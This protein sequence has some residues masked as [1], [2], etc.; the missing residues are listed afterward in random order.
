VAALSDTTTDQSWTYRRTPGGAASSAVPGLLVL[1]SGSEARL[2]PIPLGPGVNVIGRDG[3][4]GPFVQDGRVSRRHAEVSFDGAGWH[5]HDLGSR[6][7]TFLDGEPLKK[8]IVTDSSRVLRV[9][10]TLFGLMSDLRAF[11]ATS[12][13]RCDNVVLGPTLRSVWRE[14]EQAAGF[15]GVLH[16]TGES[17]SGKEL[18]ARHFHRSSARGGGPFVAVNCAAIPPNLAERLLFGAKKGAYS[19]AQADADGYLQEVDGGTLLLD[20]VAELELPV[21]AKLLRALEAKEVLP[22]GASRPTRIDFAICTA[23]HHDLRARVNAGQFRADL[24]F[25]IGTPA[26]R[27]PALRDR[28]E[29]IPWLIQ[30]ELQARPSLTA[31]V[32]LVEACLVRHWPGNVRELV[33]E[34][35]NAAGRTIADGRSR[36]AASDLGVSAGMPIDKPRD[37]PAPPDDEGILRVL[38][39][40]RGNVAAT[41]RK[42]GIHR[43][44]L[45]RWVARNQDRVQPILPMADDAGDADD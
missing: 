26:V 8:T 2:I 37:T 19:G 34:I 15:G 40:E 13:E 30:Y 6:N 11:E 4:T 35:W 29:D 3:V 10:D 44:Q 38:R 17:G 42:L 5:I 32:S 25:R 28:L 9:G 21:Q 43:T 16:I 7:G 22:L 27:L 45:R 14:I 33:A 18:A 24:L 41:A 23:T 31:H 39:E 20:E 36:I 12:V 1:F